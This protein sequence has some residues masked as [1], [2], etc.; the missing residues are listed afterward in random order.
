MVAGGVGE[1][2]QRRCSIRE[3]TAV[4]LFATESHRLTQIAGPSP[5]RQQ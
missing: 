4:V 3:S 1:W 5:V 2:K